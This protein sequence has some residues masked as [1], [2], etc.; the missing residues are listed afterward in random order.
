MKNHLDQLADAVRAF[1]EERD[2]N[3]FHSPKDLAIG[4]ST[5]A[6]ELLELFRF[7]T[8]EDMNAMMKDPVMR[9]AIGEELA[10]VLYFLLRFSQLYEFD[11]TTEFIRKMRK[12]E[13]K[14]PVETAKGSNKKYI[15]D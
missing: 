6:A 3:Q 4:V 13:L 15:S 10:D 8:D 5:E 9:E 7:K 14:Y 2:W 11:L 12:N 1:C